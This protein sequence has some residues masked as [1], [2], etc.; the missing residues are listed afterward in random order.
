MRRTI[1]LPKGSYDK[2]DAA[3]VKDITDRPRRGYNDFSETVYSEAIALVGKNDWDR[4]LDRRL[5]ALR[6][7][8]AVRCV[9][10]AWLPVA[11]V[12]A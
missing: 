2:L 5:Q 3:I 7:R 1:Q 6:K 8:G 11:A 9:N 4:A 12:D 10:Q